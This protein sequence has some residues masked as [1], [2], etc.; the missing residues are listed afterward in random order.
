MEN[1]EKAEK[2]EDEETKEEENSSSDFDSKIDD[3]NEKLEKDANNIL[4]KGNGC[5]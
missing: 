3:E 5:Q 4:I 1:L 2:I